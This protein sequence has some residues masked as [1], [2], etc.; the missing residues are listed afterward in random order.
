[1]PFHGTIDI[2]GLSQMLTIVVLGA[3]HFVSQPIGEAGGDSCEE[4]RRAARSGSIDIRG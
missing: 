4:K 1:M 3:G 2:P